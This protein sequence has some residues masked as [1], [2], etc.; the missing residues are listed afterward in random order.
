[1]LTLPWTLASSPAGPSAARNCSGLSHSGAC[2]PKQP[3]STADASSNCRADTS[4]EASSSSR[5]SN[6][7]R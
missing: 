5:W 2:A 7:S 1:M 6:A 4:P 3:R